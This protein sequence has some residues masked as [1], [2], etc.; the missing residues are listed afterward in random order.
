MSGL[1]GTTEPFGC[2]GWILKLSNKPLGKQS[3]GFG[4]ANCTAYIVV[5]GYHVRKL[6]GTFA[7]RG[8]PLE[9]S[10]VGFC[11]QLSASSFNPI[12]LTHLRG[13]MIHCFAQ[14]LDIL[15]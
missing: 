13:V 14:S 11:I 3:S 10:I 9:R 6:E 5:R 2:N 8:V 12:N 15:L 7:S 4:C 1:S